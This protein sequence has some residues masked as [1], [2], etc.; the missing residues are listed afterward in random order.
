MMRAPATFLAWVTGNEVPARLR[1]DVA[2]G[3]RATPAALPPCATY[4]PNV[5]FRIYLSYLT[6]SNTQRLR[7]L[8]RRR[9]AQHVRAVDARAA[10]G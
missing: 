3:E 7:P 8:A 2:G 5:L 6:N 9:R 10:R 4:V 1:H